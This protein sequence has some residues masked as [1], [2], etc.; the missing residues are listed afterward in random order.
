[1]EKK[2]SEYITNCKIILK[3]A[4]CTYFFAVVLILDAALLHY[5][6]KLLSSVKPLVTLWR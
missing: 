3:I 1:M 6:Y 5:V 4:N 2:E